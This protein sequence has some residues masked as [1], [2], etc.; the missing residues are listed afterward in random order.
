[1]RKRRTEGAGEGAALLGHIWTVK[2]KFL[3]G[4]AHLVMG[5]K[6]RWRR[7]WLFLGHIR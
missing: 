7:C 6:P 5:D 3:L 2:A 1:M 4:N